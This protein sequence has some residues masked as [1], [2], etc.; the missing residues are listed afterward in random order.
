[1]FFHAVVMVMKSKS[2]LIE[3]KMQLM[4]F[5]KHCYL[6]GQCASLYEMQNRQD[7]ALNIVNTF[8]F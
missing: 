6:E 8:F 4:Y 3:K 1:M 5:P 7:V 2:V